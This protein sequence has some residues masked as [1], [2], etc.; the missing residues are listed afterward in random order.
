MIDVKHDYEKGFYFGP[1][2]IVTVIEEGD[3]LEVIER[4]TGD[5]YFLED[6]LCHNF[7]P[8]DTK[9]RNLYNI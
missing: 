7:K 3:R 8:S 9:K 1:H 2:I 4:D 5:K 6:W